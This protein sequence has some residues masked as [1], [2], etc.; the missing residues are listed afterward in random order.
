[1]SSND[2]L[3]PAAGI[4]MPPFVTTDLA[5]RYAFPP[6]AVAYF[7]VRV[8]AGGSAVFA[9]AFA[10]VP[11]AINGIRTAVRRS[12]DVLIIDSLSYWLA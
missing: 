1:M 8:A 6:T 3:I 12:S 5:A 7:A 11:A 2:A 10:T 9:C 4:D